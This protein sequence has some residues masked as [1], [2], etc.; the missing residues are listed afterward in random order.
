[1]PIDYCKPVQA[2]CRERVSSSGGDLQIS[3]GSIN[4]LPATRK[5]TLYQPQETAEP[6]TQPC[7]KL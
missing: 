5:L 7:I 2:V 4:S 1:M 6:K 3:I